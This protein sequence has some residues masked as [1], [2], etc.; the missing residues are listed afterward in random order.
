M[1]GWVKPDNQLTPKATLLID[2]VESLYGKKK[3][4]V[5]KDIMGPNPEE[6]MD[7]Y[8]SLWP[9]IKLPSGKRARVSKSNLEGPMIRFFTNHPEYDW[10]LIFKATAAYCD[11]YEAKNWLYAKN[12]QYF[13]YK[14]NQTSKEWDSELANYCELM[15][16]GGYEEQHVFK[17]K[18]I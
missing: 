16:S 1:D 5:K 3:T 13:V 7:K 4:K 15:A 2:E 10:N 12:S 9:N 18:I 14:L 11:E 6:M 8:L 17:E